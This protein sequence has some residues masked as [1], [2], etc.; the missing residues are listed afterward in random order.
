MAMGLAIVA[1]LLLLGSVV[2]TSVLE[3]AIVRGASIPW[4][5]SNQS[6]ALG[7]A[8]ALQAGA[9]VFLVIGLLTSKKFAKS[10]T[11]RTRRT[12]RR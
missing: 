11:R 1:L 7:T 2:L 3:F 12:S 10:T 9:L 8:L 6:A 4:V 5:S